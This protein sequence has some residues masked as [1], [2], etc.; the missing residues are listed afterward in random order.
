MKL[1]QHIEK[2]DH[3]K[4][5]Y[6]QFF[7]LW[8]QKIVEKFNVQDISKI[9]NSFLMKYTPYFELD[10]SQK[11]VIT[12]IIN[13]FFDE[14][15]RTFRKHVISGEPGTGKTL[16]LLQI[17]HQMLYIKESNGQLHCNY[18]YDVDLKDI[19]LIIPQTHSMGLYKKWIQ[20]FGLKGIRV[21][22]PTGF[23]KYSIK[24]REM[25][26][27]TSFYRLC[28]FIY[29]QMPCSVPLSDIC[30]PSCDS[31]SVGQGIAAL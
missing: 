29:H 19:V 1:D 8:N 22:T 21:F 30:R 27:A 2:Y 6:K 23:I 31:K 24:T 14:G 17:I 3:S 10:E 7:D 15:F 4:E 18:E 11:S 12:R 20:A 13:S 25:I 26:T 28:H 5:T 16:V 9:K